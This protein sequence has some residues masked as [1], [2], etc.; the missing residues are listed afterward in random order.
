MLPFES[1]LRLKAGRRPPG[2]KRGHANWGAQAS[3]RSAR[4]P[5]PG[6][7]QGPRVTRVFRASWRDTWA[8]PPGRS[9]S[10]ERERRADDMNFNNVLDLLPRNRRLSRALGGSVYCG[11]R[12]ETEGGTCVWRR[13]RGGK[14][15]WSATDSRDRLHG[16]AVWGR[17]WRASVFSC[18][19]GP[20]LLGG[21]MGERK[22][23]SRKVG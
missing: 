5:E 18:S 23:L 22:R 19:H 13:V 4:R 2:R 11:G 3:S 9:W 10:V 15:K 17:E 21:R 12:V 20:A 14:Q 16:A 6:A 8:E 1:G 7:C